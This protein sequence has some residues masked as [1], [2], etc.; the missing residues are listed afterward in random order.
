MVTSLSST[1][2]D[3]SHAQ[4]YRVSVLVPRPFPGPL[5]YRSDTPLPPGTLVRV[6]LGKREVVGCVWGEAAPSLP[7]D[8]RPVYKT[9]TVPLEKLRSVIEN[10]PYM[11]PLPESLRHFVDWVAA[12]G[13]SAPGMVLAIATRV[14]AAGGVK[15]M[16]GWVRSAQEVPAGLRLT[17]AR[18]A[19]LKAL[20]DERPYT[21]RAL[22]EQSGAS[23]A[24]IR[25]LAQAGML[26]ER[27]VEQ[28]SA[29]ALPDPAYHPPV[30]SDSQAEAASVLV[31][32]V[33]AGRFGVTLLEGVTGSGKTEVYFE[34]VAAALRRGQQVLVLLPEIVL[35]AQWTRRFA[36]RFGVEPAVWHSDLG[37]KAR[38]ETWCAVQS[39]EARVVVGARSSLFLPFATLGLVVVDEEHESTYKQE[40]GVLYHGRDMAIVRARMVQA[41]VVLVS[42][43]PSMETLANV[44]QG[45]Y[46]HVQLDARHGGAQ[47]PEVS[48]IDLRDHSPD[49]GLFLSPVL[50]EAIE[51]RLAA[52]EQAM[53]FL[54]RRGYAP[55]TLCRAC[56]HRIQCPHCSAWMVEHRARRIFACHHCE[57]VEPLKPACPECGAEHSLVPIGPGVERIDEEV[58]A[59]FPDA[60]VLSMASD[61]LTS[62]HAMAEA[63][64]RIAHNKVNLIIGTQVVAKGWHFPNLTLVGVVDSDLGLGGGDLRA[65]ERTMQL[66]HQV[67][68]R[69]GRGDKPGQVMLQ[70]YVSDHPVMQA[71]QNNDFQAFMEQEAAQRRPGFWPPYGRL[72]AVIVSAPKESHA[73]ALSRQLALQAPEGEGIQVLG[74]A[75]APLSLLRGRYRFRLLLRTWRGIA[76]QPLLRRWLAG[77]KRSHDVKIEVDI[78][79]VSFM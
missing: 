6:P 56:G 3:A 36:D 68:G 30:L 8:L 48:L 18:Q 44:E 28:P 65:A 34:A 25:G 58:R 62:P 73:E 74:P 42:A 14:P 61:T 50:C 10:V 26:E 39:G 47:L 41:S 66:L 22:S 24:V 43:T 32:G 69:A 5:D 2:L 51:T 19:V 12:Y 46:G 53:L 33:E 78:D 54:N 67:S 15:P 27:L 7:P 75:P 55:L 59:R 13:L 38:R 79:P 29:V 76:V 49:R 52:G 57:R 23:A 9:R 35:T 31:Q 77:V 45:R 72:A 4:G 37:Q 1:R 71:L 63:V 20:S 17:P 40:E 60:S 21:T 64:T 16:M 11:P 70:S